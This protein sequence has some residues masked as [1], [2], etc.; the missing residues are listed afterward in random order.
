MPAYDAYNS[1]ENYCWPGSG[2]E[3]LATPAFFGQFLCDPPVSL[4]RVLFDKLRTESPDLD[5]ILLS[6]DYIAHA[7]ALEYPPHQ[8]F[9]TA[10]Y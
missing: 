2:S 5:V 4:V 10:D 6:G 7:I 8:S 9:K 3:V 1:N